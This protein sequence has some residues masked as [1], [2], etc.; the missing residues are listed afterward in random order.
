M[1]GDNFLMLNH[2]IHKKTQKT[3]REAIDL[4]EA[5]KKEYLNR[6]FNNE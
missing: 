4:A 5:R 6:K 3:P 1:D 2:A